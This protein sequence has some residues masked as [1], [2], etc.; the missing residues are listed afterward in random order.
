VDYRLLALA[1]PERDQPLPEGGP[2]AALGLVG[3]GRAGVARVPE[4]DVKPFDLVA[5]EQ[6]R[7]ACG[8]HLFTRV[9]DE[10]LSPASQRG[11]L[12]FVESVRRAA[13]DASLSR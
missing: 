2:E 6:D 5:E 8:A 10:S 1:G 11:Q 9:A 7:A 13:P 4:V 3:G 12:L